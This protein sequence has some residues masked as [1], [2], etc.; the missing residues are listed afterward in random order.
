MENFFEGR[1]FQSVVK[2]YY[3][4][5]TFD[6]DVLLW[7]LHVD[8]PSTKP[9]DSSKEFHEEDSQLLLKGAVL[10]QTV[11]H[12]SGNLSST[13]G[14]HVSDS[15]CDIQSDHKIDDTNDASDGLSMMAWEVHS[16]DTPVDVKGQ[17]SNIFQTACKIQDKVVA[18]A[19]LQSLATKPTDSSKEF[20][21]ED[22]QLLLKGAVLDQ[23]VMH[24]SGNLSS[25]LG[26]HVSDSSCDIQSDHKIDDTNDASDG[27][28]MMAWEVHSDDT[29][30]D[31]KGQRSNIFQTA[32][33]IQDKFKYCA[34]FVFVY[35]EASNAA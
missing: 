17:R 12:E 9:T 4:E 33:K 7:W 14:L 34:C 20:H 25:T 1:G 29:P 24:E 8:D 11:M 3:A 22:S 27:L 19:I 15:S 13:L 35:A 26:L 31:V 10:D 21:E 28:S 23:T 18:A 30:V 16:D 5:E 6:K 2:M 32:C